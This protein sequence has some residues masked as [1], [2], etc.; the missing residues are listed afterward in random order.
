MPCSRSDL[1]SPRLK[2]YAFFELALYAAILIVDLPAMA[3][4]GCLSVGLLIPALISLLEQH[5]RAA[6]FSSRSR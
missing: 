3:L 5:S 4:A 1:S 2:E 6:S